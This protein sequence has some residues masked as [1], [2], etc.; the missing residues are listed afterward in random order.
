[1]NLDHMIRRRLHSPL[2][3]CAAW[4]LALVVAADRG[5]AWAQVPE[6]FELGPN[7]QALP[8]Q[9]SASAVAPGRPQVTPD[10]VFDLYGQPQ[11][12]DIGV[13][14]MGVLSRFGHIAGPNYERTT[15]LTYLDLSPYTFVENTYFFADLRGF[16]TNEDQIGGSTG[17]GIRHYFSRFDTVLGGSFWYDMD[18]SRNGVQF[19]QV[20]ASFEMFT[21]WLDIRA[22]WYSPHGVTRKDISTQFVTGSEHF[23]G[24][25]LAFNTSTTSAASMEGVD[26]MFTVPVANEWAQRLNMEVSAGWYHF[27]ARNTK[28]ERIWGWKA[29]VDGDLFEKLFHTFLEFSSDNLYDQHVVFGLDVNYWNGQESRPRLGTSQF[30]RIAQW[31]RRNRNVVTNTQ[32]VLNPDQLAVNPNTGNAYVFAHVRNVPPPSPL[33]NP[34]FGAGDGSITNPYKY[35]PEAFAGS[36]AADVYYVHADSVFDPTTLGLPPAEVAQLNDT[37]TIPDGKLVLGEYD[38]QQHVLP[39]VGFPGG[40]TV[41]R[42]TGGSNRPVFQNVTTTGGPVIQMGNNTTFSGFSILNAGNGDGIGV[43]GVGN[44]IARDNIIDNITGNGITVNNAFGVVNLD[45]TDISNTVGNG[46]EVTGGN[47]NVSLRGNGTN[48]S[49]LH[50]VAGSFAVLIQN[51]FGSVNLTGTPVTEVNGEGVT[52]QN[53]AAAVTFQNISIISTSGT[54]GL[55]ILNSTGDVGINGDVFIQDVGG[56]AVQIINYSGTF[57]L[58]GNLGIQNRNG[59][60]VDVQNLSGAAF[61]LGNTG[62]SEGLGT[63]NEAGVSFQGSSGTLSFGNLGIQGSNAGVGIQIGDPLGLAPNTNG[64][65]FAVT[66]ATVI[67][68]ADDSAIR[69]VNDNADVLFNGSVTIDRRGPLGFGVEIFGTNGDIVFNGVTQDNNQLGQAITSLDVRQANG[70]VRFGTY[71]ALNVIGSILNPGVN[72]LNNAA[73]AFGSLNVTGVG[74]E[75]VFMR[76]NTSVSTA[77]GTVINTAAVNTAGNNVS[78]V[79]VVNATVQTG[80]L[81]FDNI[82]STGVV[83]SAISVQNMN[84][85]FQVNGTNGTAQNT[86][87]GT[88]VA[89]A[90]FDTVTD[91]S[92]ANQTYN[93]NTGGAI[94][95]TTAASLTVSNTTLNNNGAAGGAG[96]AGGVQAIDVLN[97]TLTGN[98]F[99]SNLGPNQILVDAQTVGTYFFTMLNNSVTDGAP[100]AAAGDMVRVQESGLGGSTLNLV[101]QNN[102]T[103]ATR[104]GGFRS[105][106]AGA[107][108]G[109]AVDWNGS[110]ANNSVILNNVF[111]LRGPFHTGVSIVQRNATVSNNLRYSGNVLQT[112]SSAVVGFGDT[113]LFMDFA[114][115]ADV[116]ISSNFA[117]DLTG[118]PTI[119]GFLMQA[120]NSRA[121]DLSFNGPGSNISISS[122]QI[123]FSANGGN[124]TGILF[125]S[126]TSTPQPTTIAIGNNVIRLF[127]EGN[128]I[129]DEFGILF[130]SVTGQVVLNNLNGSDNIITDQNGN[131]PITI[132]PFSIPGGASAGQIIVN[133]FPVP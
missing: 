51:N 19:D 115:Q 49:I 123:N 48:G 36:P 79:H 81:V 99:T 70:L 59:I 2:L 16:Y 34:V 50:T 39:A 32:T 83:E 108:A 14:G 90:L 33:P 73:V 128:I 76:D 46:L 107:N 26:M 95:V 94:D 66:G 63:F 78:A 44:V 9:D 116:T 114:G 62:M 71:R 11:P 97:T 8:I 112:A 53:S 37:L 131:I 57:G 87:T 117:N 72:I 29:R 102:G 104:A 4:T 65:L 132:T 24:N 5:A 60:G 80:T 129:G 89:A 42:V 27:Q 109:F 91:V 110:I 75:L 38:G 68:D 12:E 23:V 88:T 25:N 31:T 119:A 82:A 125:R 45:R 122:N 120:L 52:V 35:V 56:S 92:L 1:M 43:N 17:G 7:G 54:A 105:Q 127:D 111:D 126:I 101:V 113:G 69:I 28:L 13:G 86:I 96:D 15:S 6:G 21:Q 20:G 84:G 18:A 93:A 22:N 106:R 100:Q 47:A 55:K 67:Q 85:R 40:V 74:S 41:P 118:N 103:T 98:T 64:A 133:G 77:G 30:N 124:G 10:N 130:T 58:I 3:W 61:F 121:M